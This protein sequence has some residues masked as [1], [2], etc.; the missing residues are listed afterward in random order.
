MRFLAWRNVALRQMTPS[1]S[2]LLDLQTL[3]NTPVPGWATLMRKV[4]ALAAGIEVPAFGASGV[5]PFLV[6]AAAVPVRVR[7]R[8]AL[9][10]SVRATREELSIR[11]M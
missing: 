5:I 10:A 6:A 4:T 2:F 1:L 7:A 11:A 9:I 8:K 3:T